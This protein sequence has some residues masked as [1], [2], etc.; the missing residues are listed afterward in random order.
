M[1]IVQDMACRE[2]VELASDYLEGLLPPPL[3]AAFEEHLQVCPG[4]TLYL[5]QMRLTL[6]A[7]RALAPDA[8]SAQARAT[9]VRQFRSWSAGAH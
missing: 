2:F 4:C 8:L 9:L 7:L 6:R 5:G 3:S 1:A